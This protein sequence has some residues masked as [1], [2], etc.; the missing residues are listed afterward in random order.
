MRDHALIH[1]RRVLAFDARLMHR[2]CFRGD[3]RSVSRRKRQYL[4]EDRQG[5]AL[6]RRASFRELG[7]RRFKIISDGRLAIVQHDVG[8]RKNFEVRDMGSTNCGRRRA[9]HRRVDHDGVC[10][11]MRENTER[12]ERLG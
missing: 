4:I 11:R 2:V 1:A 8:R 12:I 6:D 5:P 10:D 3:D 7:E 9:A